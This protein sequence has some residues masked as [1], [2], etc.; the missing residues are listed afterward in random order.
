[1]ISWLKSPAGNPNFV[2]GTYLVT[3]RSREHD[4]LP[5]AYE[6]NKV[7]KKW[8]GFWLQNGYFK[9]IID[10]VFNFIRSD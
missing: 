8:Y 10:K 1:M 9:P 3:Q 4:D 5:R 2:G 6:P 7:E